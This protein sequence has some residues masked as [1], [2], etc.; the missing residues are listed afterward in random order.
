MDLKN[1]SSNL[2]ALHWDAPQIARCL[3]NKDESIST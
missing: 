1:Y 3:Q 2:D